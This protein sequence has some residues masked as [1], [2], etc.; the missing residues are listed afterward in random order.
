MIHASNVIWKFWMKFCSAECT[1][2][3]RQ[4]AKLAWQDDNGIQL[5]SQSSLEELLQRPTMQLTFSLPLSPIVKTF[6]AVETQ[7]LLHCMALPPINQ[8]ILT[9]NGMFRARLG[10]STGWVQLD[11]PK[12]I[13][14]RLRGDTADLDPLK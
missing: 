9:F 14:W 10:P 8:S 11:E 6:S 12:T 1:E 13:C 5:K 3:P 2:Y 4:L 7:N